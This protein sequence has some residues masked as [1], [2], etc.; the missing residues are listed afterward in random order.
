MN[1]DRRNFLR[2]VGGGVAVSETMG[3]SP[4][5]RWN[6][7]AEAAEVPP[8]PNIVLIMADDLGYGSLGCYGSKGI[9]TPNIDRLARNGMRLTDFHS[10]APMCSP[11]RASLLTGR[12]PQRCAW[13]DD[14]ELSPAFRQQRKDN[15][16]QRWAFGISIDELTIADLVKKAGYETALFG[17]WHLGYDS[18]FH[19][20]N[21]GFDE[22]RGF[23]GGAIDYHT[24][25]A[26][27]GLKDLDWWNGRKME[28]EDGYATDLL[29]HYAEG[30]IERQKDQPFFL[31][32]SHAAPHVPLQGRDPGQRKSSEE[33]YREMIEVLDESVG[34]IE[35]ALRKHN[36]HDK[37][38]VIFC[39]D[40]GPFPQYGI[41]L[42]SGLRGQKGSLY[43]GGHRVPCILSWPGVIPA[44]SECG[45]PVLTMDFFPT[46]AKLAGIEPPAGLEIDGMNLLPV[47]KGN[48]GDADR[49]V[50]WLFDD[51]W[52]VRQGTWKLIGKGPKAAKLFNLRDDI[53]ETNN[54]IAHEAGRADELMNLHREWLKVVGD[55]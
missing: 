16:K 6:H 35:A 27:A 38:L 4:F 2:I 9:S 44:S 26:Q 51:A 45:A 32:L 42:G 14:A 21:Q 50:H 13:V 36:L 48:P 28:N 8:Q 19:P 1:L 15:L 24:H 31:Y 25:V 23:I 33:T 47:M 7:A 43:E 20:M 17:K 54:T 11:T 40:N 39:S 41:N 55:K 52:A 53:R 18:R 46:V 49:V 34:S 10:N 3:L 37:T 22:F 12:Y 29:T 30:F 5:S